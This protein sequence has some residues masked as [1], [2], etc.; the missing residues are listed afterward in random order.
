MTMKSCLL[1]VLC[2]IGV[3]AKTFELFQNFDMSQ[4]VLQHKFRQGEDNL[5]NKM[6]A[7]R[8]ASHDLSLSFYLDKVAFKM[9]LQNIGVDIP[10]VYYM[11][12]FKNL[13][14]HK[15]ERIQ[16]H[17]NYNEKILQ[18]Y[19]A[20][21]LAQI[22]GRQDYVAKVSH[23]SYADGV[24]VIKNFHHN[25]LAD[26][27]LIPQDSDTA[28]VM[29]PAEVA[30]TLAEFVHFPSLL[31]HESW[32]LNQVQPGLVVEERMTGAT[33]WGDDNGPGIEF[34]TFTI[35]GKAYVTIW[36]QL[37]KIH[38]MVFRNGTAL[39]MAGDGQ[40]REMTSTVRQLPE[41]LDWER[42][43]AISE[44]LGANKDMF[45]TDVFVGVPASSSRGPEDVTYVV[46][47]V[48]IYSTYGVGLL[49]E[50]MGRLWLQGY[51]DGEYKV[52][53]NHESSPDVKESKHNEEGDTCPKEEKKETWHN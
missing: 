26:F 35:W 19:T 34:K 37:G 42:V 25:L 2:T 7:L 11:K 52:I 21:I 44:R 36:C 43:V 17:H 33:S 30:R 27:A 51:L 15:H 22:Q 18:N 12:H 49:E 23:M 31:S 39:E 6:N 10:P 53:P 32:A 20:Q 8:K 24:V 29:Y 45:R 14:N 9:H 1:F 40:Y 46:S 5:Y 16:D 47:E 13:F 50:E 41:W 48:E 3:L 38:A 4:S 28:D